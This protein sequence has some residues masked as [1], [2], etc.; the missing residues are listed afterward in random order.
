M[1]FFTAQFSK[2]MNDVI[3]PALIGDSAASFLLNADIESGKIKSMKSPVLLPQTSPEQFEHYG[4]NKRSVA[5][6]YERYYWSD[7]TSNKAPYYGGDKENY[8]GIP[9]P[10]YGNDVVFEKVSDGNHS[11]D[12][13]YCVTFVNE[14]GWEGAPGSLTEYEKKFTLNSED[15]KIT[16]K[17]SDERISYAKIYRTQK[18]GADFYCVGEVKRSGESFTD[19]TDDYTLVGLEMISTLDNYPPPEKGKYL[20]ESG[21]VFF[22]AVGSTLYFSVLGNPHG[23]PPLNFIG[24]DDV[25]TG[26]TSEFQG[27]LVFTSN[28][29]YQITGAGDVTTVTKVL[30]PGNQGC[31]NYRSISHVSNAP[32]WLSNDGLC[33]W[34][35]ESVTIISKQVLNTSRLQVSTAVSANDR[36]YLFLTSGG[37]IFDHRNGSVFYKTD[38]SC[39]YAWYD[40]DSDVIYM[41]RGESIYRYGYGEESIFIYR[42]GHIGVPESQYNYYR[43]VICSIE[44]DCKVTARIDGSDIFS[45]S[46]VSGK[47]R[48]KFPYDTVGR[49]CEIEVS[50][51]GEL[52]EL[53]VVYG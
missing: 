37:I 52:S 22:L 33:M 30:L 11:G 4:N 49:Y 44:G 51:I 29:A 43:E 9:Y 38:F 12:Y 2:G 40:S 1:A 13:K 34:N 48:L 20:T 5:K 6:W 35:G 25:I 31:P 32:V 23:W 42:S 15:M 45:V 28:N 21:G 27:V 46:V 47:H 19:S 26:I 3:D 10:D 39:E 16:V 14:N 24:F 8:L 7:N 41:Q 50:G 36:Y 53:G 17:W 18:E